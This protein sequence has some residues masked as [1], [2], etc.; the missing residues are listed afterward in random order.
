[1]QSR[2]EIRRKFLRVRFAIAVCRRRWL[3][4]VE[5]NAGL[6]AVLSLK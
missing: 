1:M 5:L 6:K 4:T 3:D 2:F